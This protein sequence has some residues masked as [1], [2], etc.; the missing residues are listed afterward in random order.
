LWIV[1]AV[2]R[3]VDCNELRLYAALNIHCVDCSKAEFIS[4]KKRMIL[5]AKFFFLFSNTNLHDK[6][7]F[8]FC[9]NAECRPGLD[10]TGLILKVVIISALY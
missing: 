9:K 5:V 3:G 7:I 2:K 8:D 1:Q 10:K 4:T 6:Q